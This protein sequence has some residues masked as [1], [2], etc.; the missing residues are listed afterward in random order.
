MTSRG[1][2]LTLIVILGFVALLLY[3]TLSAQRVECEVCVAFDGGRNCA[4]ASHSTER[5]AARSAQ[6]T[7]CGPLAKGMDQAIACGNTPPVSQQCRVR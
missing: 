2:V 6:T 3:N 5:D 1:K 7:A 4:A